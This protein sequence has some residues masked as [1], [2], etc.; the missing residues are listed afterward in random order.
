MSLP[1]PDG[2]HDPAAPSLADLA[3]GVCSAQVLSFGADG[4]NGLELNWGGHI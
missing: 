1:G 4:E 2:V 3:T